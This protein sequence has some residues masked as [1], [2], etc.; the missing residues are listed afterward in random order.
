MKAL[1]YDTET[2]GL[3][4][5]SEPSEDPRQPHIVQ[6]AA[7]LVDLDTRKTL[8][9]LDLTIAPLGWEIPEDVVKIHGITTAH[10]RSVGV[11]EP[12]AVQLFME[13]W[14]RADIRVGHNEQFD[15]RI[16]RCALH[17]YPALTERAPLWKA[18]R[19]ECTQQMATPILKL[20]PTAKMVAAGFNKHKSANLREAYRHFFGVDFTGAHSAIADAQA[21]FEVYTAIKSP[22]AI[23]AAAAGIHS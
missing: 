1:V 13:L 19:S 5:F 4:L 2:T 23:P 7:L 8:S 11:P 18:G 17:R 15:A 3:P 14:S 20:P 6:L 9:T 22:R 12:L 21:C 16:V 10:A